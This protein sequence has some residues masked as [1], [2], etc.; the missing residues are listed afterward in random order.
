MPREQKTDHN[1]FLMKAKKIESKIREWAVVN[2]EIYVVTA[3]VLNDKISKSIGLNS[4]SVP[5]YFYKVVLC[6]SESNTKGIGFL[7]EN[8][9]G[10]GLL[11]EYAVSI[12]II[13]S[14]TGINFFPS[15]PDDIENEIEKSISLEDWGLAK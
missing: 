3:G 13:E 1:I 10:T 4:V 11:E 6:Y 7:I 12:D 15:L 5:E 8:K 2:N 9:R 14:I